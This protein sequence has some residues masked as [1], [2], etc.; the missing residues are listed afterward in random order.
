MLLEEN[1][2]EQAVLHLNA[3]LEIAGR[4]GMSLSREA[5]AADHYL[6]G[7]AYTQLGKLSLAREQLKQS[8]SINPRFEKA[9]LLLRQIEK[10]SLSR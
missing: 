3:G 6:L 8:L 10:H 4:P 1:Q 2:A 7:V 9:L 5:A